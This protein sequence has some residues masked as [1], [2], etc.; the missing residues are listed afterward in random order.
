[1]IRAT[2]FLGLDSLSM[3]KFRAAGGLGCLRNS[4][5]ISSIN[6]RRVVI[7]LSGLLHA[8]LK[9]THEA[10]RKPLNTKPQS[11]YVPMKRGAS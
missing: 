8:L 3:L 7:T 11:S 5:R 2:G 4:C 1:M 10:S 9:A 6:S